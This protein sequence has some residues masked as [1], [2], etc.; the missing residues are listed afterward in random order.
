MLVPKFIGANCS[1][2]PLEEGR[3]C[4]S[5]GPLQADILLVGEYPGEDE[6]A[7]NEPF[8]GISGQILRGALDRA[9]LT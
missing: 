8:F 4:A 5:S 9:G 6:V 3:S 2:C 1:G 7:A